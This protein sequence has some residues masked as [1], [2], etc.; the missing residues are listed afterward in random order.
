[1]RRKNLLAL[2][3]AAFFGLSFAS[4]SA[5]V[6][7][8]FDGDTVQLQTG[9][10]VRYLGIDTPEMGDVPEF[11][12]EEARQLNRRMVAGKRVRLEFDRESEDRHGRKLAYVF[13]ENGDMVN[14]LLLQKGLAHILAPGPDLKYFSL[15]LENQRKAMKEGVGIWSR[16]DARDPVFGNTRSFIFHRPECDRGKETSKRNRK[17]FSN[18]I[19][20]FWEAYHP[21]RICKP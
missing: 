4:S 8:V 19:S 18:R 3:F 6:R 17:F 15:F 12:A 21:C 20:A 5:L 14:I 9:E 10:K 1:M 13:L 2:L 16:E 7:I 11:M